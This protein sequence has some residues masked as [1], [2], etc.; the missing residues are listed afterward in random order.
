VKELDWRYTS[1]HV[2]KEFV[3]ATKSHVD[4]ALEIE[5]YWNFYTVALYK[6]NQKF[7]KEYNQ[8][9]MIDITIDVFRQLVRKHRKIDDYKGYFYAICRETLLDHEMQKDR[10]QKNIYFDDEGNLYNWLEA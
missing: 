4:K 5:S 9:D 2:P 8:F 3:D 6:H 7:E 10:E 1:S